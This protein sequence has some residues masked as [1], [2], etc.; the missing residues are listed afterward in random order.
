[1]PSQVQ[2]RHPDFYVDELGSVSTEKASTA[3]FNSMLAKAGLLSIPLT[4]IILLF[5]FGSLTAALI[6]LMLALTAVMATMGLIA[7]P[8]SI[9]PMEETVNEV[10]LLIGLAV[11][12]D[13][14]LFYIKR[15]REERRAGRSEQPRSRPLPQPPAGRCSSPASP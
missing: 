5:V 8:S 15:E 10:I 9:V 12:V 14:S 4:L 2:K 3:A 7:F 13:Y 1:M 6:P 11:G